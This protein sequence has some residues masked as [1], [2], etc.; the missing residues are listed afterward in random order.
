MEGATPLSLA[1]ST[2]QV[3]VQEQD[4]Q[5]EVCSEGGEARSLRLSSCGGVGRGEVPRQPPDQTVCVPARKGMCLSVRGWEQAHQRGHRHLHSRPGC[6]CNR[7]LQ[8]VE[9]GRGGV[10]T[11]LRTSAPPRALSSCILEWDQRFLTA[12]SVQFSSVQS[13]SCIWLF[14]CQ[15][16]LSITSSQSLLKLM[17][18]ELVMSSNH[19]I[20]CRPLLLPPSIFPSTRGSSNESVL[21]IR[22]PNTGISASTSVLPMNTQVWSPLGW[23]GWIS[24]QS[25]GLSRVFSNT[26]VHEHQFFDSSLG[27]YRTPVGSAVM[28][29]KEVEGLGPDDL[30]L[31]LSCG[32]E[33]RSGWVAGTARPSSGELSSP[34]SL[35]S[36]P[37]PPLP[38]VSAAGP[39]TPWASV[40]PGTGSGVVTWGLLGCEASWAWARAGLGRGGGEENFFFQFYL[41]I[42]LLYNIVLVWSPNTFYTNMR[43]IF[44]GS[45]LYCLT[46][47]N[48]TGHLFSFCLVSCPKHWIN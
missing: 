20:L 8:G 3:L 19:L 15:V 10:Q 22:W 38:G 45:S 24:L 41:F 39:V 47:R 37:W 17:S 43:E 46:I 40:L 44:Q 21:Y 23:T 13:L 7:G 29:S 6:R 26:T 34:L 32:A 2:E 5:P 25:K 28:D 42:F 14:A 12:L 16:S 33:D 11:L 27:S 4:L 48:Q 35:L 9:K 30:L 18:I 1:P 36:V 31:L